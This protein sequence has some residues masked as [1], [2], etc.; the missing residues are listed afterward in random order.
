MIGEFITAVL[1]G[2]GALFII[3]VTVVVIAD[4]VDN[5]RRKALNK[6]RCEKC[7][8]TYKAFTDSYCRQC[9]NKLK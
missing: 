5:S 7:G 8:T 9:G 3:A 2:V 6:R 4:C 1:A